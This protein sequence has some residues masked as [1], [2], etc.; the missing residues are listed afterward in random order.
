[1]HEIEPGL[2]WIG[3]AFD[4]RE[5]RLLFDAGIQAV[6]DVA[7]EEVPARLPRQLMYFRFPINDGAGNAPAVIRLALDTVVRL[8]RLEVPVIVCCSAGM[9]RSPT[10]AA[11]SLSLHLETTPDN[12]IAAISEKRSLEIKPALWAEFAEF[13]K[14]N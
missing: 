13:A 8:L 6:V 7:F 1:M 12:I 5:Y 14:S 4:V 11:F 2:L 9:S 10:L 3:N